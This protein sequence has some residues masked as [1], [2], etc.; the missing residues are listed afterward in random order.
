MPTT[1]RRKKKTVHPFRSGYRQ[2]SGTLDHAVTVE[3][4]KAAL[5]RHTELWDGRDGT[6]AVT[7]QAVPGKPPVWKVIVIA[8]GGPFLH[9][10]TLFPE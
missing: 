5:P 10:P 6:K 4:V 3:E 9:I 1:S 7:V 8:K 2:F